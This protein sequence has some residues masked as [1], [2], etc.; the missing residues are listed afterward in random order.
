MVESVA[1]SAHSSINQ[2]KGTA[3]TAQSV[4]DSDTIINSWVYALSRPGTTLVIPVCLFD[5]SIK[6]FL[7]IL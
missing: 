4:G 5:Y 1:V 3:F 7:I 2:L 6:F